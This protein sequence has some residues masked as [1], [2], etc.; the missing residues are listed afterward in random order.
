M[1]Q[2]E[3]EMT[4][5]HSLIGVDSVVDALMS[6]LDAVRLS[7]PTRPVVV[8]GPAGSGRSSVLR[9]AAA[10][11]VRQGWWVGIADVSAH[12]T[13]AS[14]LDLAVE[15]ALIDC[16]KGPF[17]ERVSNA[18]R[19]FVQEAASSPFDLSEAFNHLL[20]VL[21]ADPGSSRIAIFVDDLHHVAPAA[22]RALLDGM[23]TMASTGAPA[24]LIPSY[25]T[26][27]TQDTLDVAPELINEQRMLPF[28]SDDMIE[29]GLRY[30]LRL[31]ADALDAFKRVTNGNPGKVVAA[32]QRIN[33]GLRP[34]PAQA[35]PVVPPPPP[36]PM[37]EP[38]AETHHPM[39]TSAHSAG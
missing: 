17:H 1:G 7:Y 31:D 9:A 28:T 37:L 12:G 23:I 3:R 33:R 21:A 35:A 19:R 8:T 39:M 18:R 10:R 26:T 38:V 27:S 34:A 25:Q 14:A 16:P 5:N 32:L 4:G 30:G 2:G 6:Q 24:G 29:L 11:A 22:R 20:P 13:L 15:D 36:V